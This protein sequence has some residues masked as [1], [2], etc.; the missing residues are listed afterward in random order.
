MS[1]NKML[2][3]IFVPKRD[4]VGGQFRVLHNMELCDLFVSTSIFRTVKFR[5]F[6]GLYM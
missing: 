4:E 3:K 6:G 2:R 1:E 5:T